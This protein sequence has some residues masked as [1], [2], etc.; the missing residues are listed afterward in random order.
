MD[1]VFYLSGLALLVSAAA[2][3]VLIKLEARVASQTSAT[4][5]GEAEKSVPDG[6]KEDEAKG[7]EA[8]GV[9]ANDDEAKEREVVKEQE[10]KEREA[11][12]MKAKEGEAKEK[13]TKEEEAKEKETKEE[14]EKKREAKGG[15]GESQKETLVKGRQVCFEWG[16]FFTCK[17]INKANNLLI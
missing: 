10:V 14:E 9:E 11:K 5:D 7:G 3:V 1:A 12:D 6:A 8:G 17:C 16:F 15:D 13:E 2:S 4:D